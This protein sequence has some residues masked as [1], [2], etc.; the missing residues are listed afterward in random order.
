MPDCTVNAQSSDD[1]ILHLCPNGGNATPTTSP[2]PDK[3]SGLHRVRQTHAWPAHPSHSAGGANACRHWMCGAETT[4][5]AK[6]GNGSLAYK[7]PS[8]H[9]SLRL[10][11]KPE[12][13]LKAARKHRT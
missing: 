4:T 8:I 9:Q 7:N 13:N 11:R 1:G 3:T 6:D 2:T 12:A 5:D 10:N